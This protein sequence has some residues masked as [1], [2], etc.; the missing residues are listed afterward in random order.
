MVSSGTEKTLHEAWHSADG[1]KRR[2]ATAEGNRYRVLYAGMPGGSLGP[3]FRDAGFEAKDG[4]EVWGD[5]EIH[6][7]AADW[8]AHGHDS[9]ANYGGVAFHLVVDGSPSRNGTINSVGMKIPEADIGNFVVDSELKIDDRRCRRPARADESSTARW[10]DSAGDE[11]FALK[12]ESRR[13]DVDRFG[14]D[15]ALQLAIFEGLGYPRNRKAFRH[16][17]MRMPWA[18]LARFARAQCAEARGL[19]T[20]AGELLRWSAGFEG[21]PRWVDVPRL[22]GVAPEWTRAASRPSNRPESRIAAAA[23]IIAD[24]W[25]H[26][27]PLRHALSAMRKTEQSGTIADAYRC[28]G[29]VLG[30]GRAGE[31]VINAV[32][33]TVAA[34][35]QSGRDAAL[36]AEA[37]AL[38]RDHPSLPMNSVLNEAVRVLRVR[39][40]P[41]PRLR[42]AR[43]QQGVMH[44]YRQMVTRPRASHQMRLGSPAL[45]S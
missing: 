42:C 35:A 20:M 7:D 18:Y 33:P 14:P 13:V 6:R 27:G 26:G 10:L 37:N 34:W 17:A 11:R 25:R 12:I 28:P 9:D 19:E 2:I 4:S 22:A 21:P 38:Y 41:V 23:R 39:G 29:G 45:S 24:W 30:A 44:I 15:L 32:L 31:I 40:Y 8:Y 5:V 36:Y 43:R 3:D 16:L 1:E